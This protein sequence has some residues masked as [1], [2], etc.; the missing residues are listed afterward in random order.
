MYISQDFIQ[1]LAQQVRRRDLPKKGEITKTDAIRYLAPEILKLRALGFKLET[2]QTFLEE[3]GLHASMPLIK[4][5]LRPA[6]LLADD[7]LVEDTDD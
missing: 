3:A 5:T 2:I 7:A 6:S 1:D 4:K